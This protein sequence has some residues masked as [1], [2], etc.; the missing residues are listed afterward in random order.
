MSERR[1]VY[2]ILKN[3]VEIAPFHERFNF[4]SMKKSITEYYEMDETLGKHSIDP[5]DVE[6]LKKI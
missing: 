2:I 4:F 6:K 5:V 3:L 1:K